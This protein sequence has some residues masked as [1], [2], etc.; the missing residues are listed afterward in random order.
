MSDKLKIV[1]VGNGN[2]GAALVDSLLAK[3]SDGIEITLYGDEEVGTYDRVR[4]SEYMAGVLDLDEL[5][6]RSDEWYEEQNISFLRGVHLEEVD[7][8]KQKV[9]GT[10]GE[11]VEYDR[12]IFATG[13][14]S[15]V[16]L[17]EGSDKEGVFVFRT[18]RD[19]E[20]MLEAAYGLLTQESEVTVLHRSG[21]LMNQQLDPPAGRMLKREMEKMGV[22]VRVEA[23]TDEILGNGKVEGV[24]L[25]DDEYL[26]ADMVVIC[27]GIVPNSQPAGNAGIRAN[28]GILVN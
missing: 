6:M 21:H 11:W 7:T 16:P 17:I 4:L 1:V 22:E 28:S 5:G 23:D 19:V 8:K 27:T 25:R 20:D 9:K 12:L 26:P 24:R 15:S 2:A 10:D 14:S 3:D 18:V 13:S